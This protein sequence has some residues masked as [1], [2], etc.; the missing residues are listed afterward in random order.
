MEVEDGCGVMGSAVAA[1]RAAPEAVVVMVEAAV[2]V[3]R[4]L[5]S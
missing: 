3:M 4:E 5:R 2:E 1:A